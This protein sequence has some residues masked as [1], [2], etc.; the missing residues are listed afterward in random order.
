[1]NP[2]MEFIGTLQKRWVKAYNGPLEGTL[3]GQP[4]VSPGAPGALLAGEMLGLKLLRLEAQ[5]GDRSA[6]RLGL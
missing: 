5:K 2:N 4:C 1:M 6:D 3:A